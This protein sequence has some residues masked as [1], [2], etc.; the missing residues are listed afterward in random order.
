MRHQTVRTTVRR[1]SW[2]LLAAALAAPCWAALGDLEASVSSDSAK[3]KAS[4]RVESRPSFTI[5]EMQTPA[6]TVVREFVAASGVVFAVSWRGPLKP[7]LTLLLGRYFGAYASAP[8][9]PGATRSRL[10][11]DQPDLIV[12]AGGRVRAFAGIALVPQLLPAN[13]TEEDLR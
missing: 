7:D 9:S 2:L 8:R 12:H 6:G 5:H 11:I 13:V 10:M 3:L 4:P 1:I